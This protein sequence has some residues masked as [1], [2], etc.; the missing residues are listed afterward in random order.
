M[1]VFEKLSSCEDL[2]SPGIS[3]CIGCNAEL[4][5]RTCMRILGP[6]TILAIPPDCMGGVVGLD[7][8]SGSKTP[9]LFSLLDNTASMLAGL[10]LHYKSLERD[11]VNVV[12]FAGDDAAADAG[13]QC[14]SGAAERGDNIIYICSQRS[15]SAGKDIAM[16]MAMHDIPYVATMNPAFIPDM[17]DKVEKAK[18]VKN[19]MVFLYVFN[20][21][22]TG[23]GIKPEE[24]IETARMAVDSL[25]SPLYEVENGKFRINYTPKE[26][27]EVREYLKKCNKFSKL[28]EKEISH[29][30]NLADHK[31]KRLQKLCEL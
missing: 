4:T 25:L 7:K 23:L 20:P 3:A 26:P 28:S 6:D 16:I 24:S 10:K 13:F 15:G 19:G 17:V 30:Q 14:L 8:R 31:W 21:C 11:E 2:I 29:L 22:V 27:V 12:A 5:L 9:V 18:T 1:N